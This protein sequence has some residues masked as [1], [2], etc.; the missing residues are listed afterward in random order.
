M[1]NEGDISQQKT[2]IGL[3]KH[4]LVVV[5]GRFYHYDGYDGTLHKYPLLYLVGEKQE[6]S[7]YLI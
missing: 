1:F 5:N 7:K 2:H 3:N 4:A 6:E